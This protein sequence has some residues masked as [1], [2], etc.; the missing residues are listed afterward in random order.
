M[1]IKYVKVV[2]NP[3]LVRETNSGGIVNVDEHAYR[4]YKA[5]KKAR[6]MQQVKEQ[7]QES[8]INMLENKISGMEQTL[9]Q[10]LDILKNDRKS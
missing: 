6:Q 8:R 3:D 2:D 4:N 1:S 9:T 5:S 10:I 7:Q